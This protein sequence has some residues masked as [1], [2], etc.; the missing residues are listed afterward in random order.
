MT[1]HAL[2]KIVFNDGTAAAVTLEP[3]AWREMSYSWEPVPISSIFEAYDGS[4]KKQINSGATQKWTLSVTVE[5]CEDPG[6]DS[7]SQSV[8]W[9]VTL[10]DRDGQSAHAYTLWPIGPPQQSINPKIAQRSW[11]IRFREE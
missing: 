1:T 10:I 6:L 3:P 7:L 2:H 5:G 8:T 11:T 4:A 9:T